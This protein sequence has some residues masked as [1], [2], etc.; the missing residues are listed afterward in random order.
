[1]KTIMDRVG[2][3]ALLAALL[4]PLNGFAESEKDSPLH[5]EME[6]MNHAFRLVNRQYTDVSQKTSTLALVAEMQK[7]AETAKTLT[8]PKAAKL[9]GDPQTKYL[10]A[11]RNDLNKLIVE[12]KALNQA[13][14]A[15]QVDLA[16]AEIQKIGQ[17]KESSHKEMGVESGRHH[18]PPPGAPATPPPAPPPGQ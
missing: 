8:P 7:H 15:D 11:F 5:A 4:V 16:K 18:G 14:T 9:A 6:A 13:I 12:I 2:L 3:F 17:L 10:D 1:M